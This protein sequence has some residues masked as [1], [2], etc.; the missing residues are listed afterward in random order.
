M[1][2]ATEDRA[3]LSRNISDT[4]SRQFSGR[5]PRFDIRCWLSDVTGAITNAICRQNLKRSLRLG[6][7]NRWRF[8]ATPQAREWIAVGGSV[9]ADGAP[10]EGQASR[11][12]R[13]DDRACLRHLGPND[14]R[15]TPLGCRRTARSVSRKGADVNH[16]GSLSVSGATSCS[17]FVLSCSSGCRSWP[18]SS[19]RWEGPS[20]FH[21]TSGGLG[22][23]VLQ[24][25]FVGYYYWLLDPVFRFT[26]RTS[27][28]P[29]Q[30]TLVPC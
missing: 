4:V 9:L 27:L 18:T 25:L 19:L 23:A 14:R 26:E 11:A 2:L 15:R 1:S 22:P 17:P 12:V 5:C 30:I 7:R 10:G 16:P 8:S 6:I 13:A 28:R 20:S 3:R 24:P 21:C 29:N